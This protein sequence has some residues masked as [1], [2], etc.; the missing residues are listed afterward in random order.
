VRWPDLRPLDP[1]RSIKVKLALLVT[2]SVLATALLT[3]YG[4]IVLGWRVRYTLP[5]AVVAAL[6]VT[7]LLARGMTSPLRQM[8]AAARAM[9]AGQPAP[10]VRATS[11]DEIG[12]LARAFTAM[13]RDLATVE[14]QRRELLANVSHE[15]RTPLA[16]LRAQLENL[17]DGVRAAD[18]SAL[19][20]VL[21]QVERLGRLV[22]DLLDLARADAGVAVL[23]RSQVGVEALVRDVVQQVGAARPGRTFHI[24][25]A[26][27]DL[28]ADAD[29]HRLRQ[30]VT[31]LV[32]NAA[33]HAPDGGR[34]DVTARADLR[35]GLV[36]EVTDD[37]PG[38]PQHRRDAVFERFR[39]GGTG[40]ISLEG[41][42]SSV[43][44]ASAGGTGLGLAIARWAVVLH[45]GQIGVVPHEAGGCRIRAEIP[46]RAPLDGEAGPAGDATPD[47]GP[48]NGDL[49]QIPTP[50]TPSTPIGAHTVVSMTTPPNALAPAPAPSASLS[51]GSFF[52]T[53]WPEPKAPPPWGLLAGA[54]AT[55]LFAAMLVVG[56]RPGINMAM[57]ALIGSSSLVAINW[58]RL[59]HVRRVLAGMAVA[60]TTVAAVRDS[61]QLVTISLLAAF[62]LGAMVAL[63]GRRWLAVPLVVPAL[64]VAGV[65]SVPW[66]G[67]RLTGSRLPA[68]T[69][70]W[71]LGL[72]VGLA[73]A[74][75]VTALLGS[76]DAAF[77]HLLDVLLPSV[78]LGLLPARAIVLVLATVAVLA[79]GFA[80]STTLWWGEGR[81]AV[82]RRRPAVEWALPLALV[83][84]V[85]A[86]FMVVQAAVLFG[87]DSEV[88][89]EGTGVTYAE[90]ARQ[91]F[92]Q[93]VVV[94]L[95]TLVLLAWAG[96]WADRGH[97]GVAGRP[98]L[99]LGLAG[100]M[101]GLTLLLVVS[102]LRRLWLYEQAYGW[103][104]ARITAGVFEIWLGV[105]L[106]AVAALWLVRRTAW[107]AVVV[108]GSAAVVLLALGLAGPD[109]MAASWNV[110]RYERTGEIDPDY[111]G[112]LS[113]DAVP[114]LDRLPAGLRGCILAGRVPRHDPW[115]AANVARIRAASRLPVTVPGNCFGVYHDL[116]SG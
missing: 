30:V 108:V 14:A 112:T 8:T 3:W 41:I 102:A 22:D 4:L 104:V 110:D 114:A 94:T 83:D 13:S 15:L 116:A 43:A 48:G 36:L 27:T 82:A 79:A 87:G 66:T 9:A 29:P 86:T 97:Q 107:S 11:R 90:R 12:E 17:V 55:G 96:R 47:G 74:A 60:L 46:C 98:A 16:A 7:Q 61:P 34:V 89:L 26:P 49:H 106:V 33:R 24:D 100:A 85:L 69:W 84:I 39:R 76:A 92:G 109:A 5:V 52:D 115:Y 77:G 32:D 45:G 73:C 31:N 35:G 42:R 19:A 20:E 111:L 91:G 25:V 70:S 38:I 75:A 21:D 64:G 62:G 6:G 71:V 78:D 51:L 56:V 113:D 37:G 54:A 67:R 65:R 88:L 53:R 2:A 18:D 101:C 59:S 93:L 103:T 28:K 80:S 68:S 99:L 23:E 81:T 95:L 72:G 10:P 105:V 63:D 1:V 44:A 40:E 58:R 50:W 57:V